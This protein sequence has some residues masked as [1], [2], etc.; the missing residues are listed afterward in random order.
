MNEFIVTKL[1]ISSALFL[2]LTACVAPEEAPVAR[3]MTPAASR[4][5]L[6]N[7][8]FEDAPL[9]NRKMGAPTNDSVIRLAR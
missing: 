5:A 8:N 9:P 7:A 3:R 1:L 2:G 6:S 4:P